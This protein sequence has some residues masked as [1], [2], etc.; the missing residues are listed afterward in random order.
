MRHSGWRARALIGKRVGD[1]IKTGGSEA[2][3]MAIN[4]QRG[5]FR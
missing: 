4:Q 3:I 5:I 2:G 1:V